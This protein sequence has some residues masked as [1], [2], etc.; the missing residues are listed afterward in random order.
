MQPIS[1][2]IRRYSNLFSLVLLGIVA[3][4]GFQSAQ[5]QLVIQTPAELGIEA[6]VEEMLKAYSKDPSF[7]QFDMV[8]T[9]D[10]G[11]T[12]GSPGLAD[13]LTVERRLSLFYEYARDIG[14]VMKRIMS[15]TY[16]T[17]LL[18]PVNQAIIALPHKPHQDTVDNVEISDVRAKSNVERFV[19]AHSLAT[20]I[21]WPI[22]ESSSGASYDSMLGDGHKVSFRLNG[23]GDVRVDPGDIK[24]LAMKD[25][26]NGRIL[27]LDGIIQY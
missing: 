15:P 26:S 1:F 17:T 25:A 24:V 18:V 11:G 23:N 8:G 9:Q 27:Y 5:A 6:Q 14:P 22:D 20:T 4:I 16:R 3:L 7:P 19:K 10:V 21:T 2:A 13:C 12:P